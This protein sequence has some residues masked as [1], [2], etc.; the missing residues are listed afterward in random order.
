MRHAISDLAQKVGKAKRKVEPVVT[1]DTYLGEL[2]SKFGERLSDA[3]NTEK[4]IPRTES[5]ALIKQLKD[6]IKERGSRKP[7]TKPDARRP[8]SMSICCA[9]RSSASR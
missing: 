3:A 6:E 9:S 2:R 8:A 4:H 1:D 7:M 5:Y